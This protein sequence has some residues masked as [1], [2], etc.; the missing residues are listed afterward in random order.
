MYRLFLQDSVNDCGAACLATILRYHGLYVTP[1]DLV[2]RLALTR[3]GATNKVL[4]DLAAEFGLMSRVIRLPIESFLI[5]WKNPV[6]PILKA[7][8][9]TP[10]TWSSSS[11]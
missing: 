11:R 1:I 10:N 5:A 2:K 7:R 6:W 4:Q 9:P 3:G 8:C